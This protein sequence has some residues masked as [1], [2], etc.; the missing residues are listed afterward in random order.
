MTDVFELSYAGTPKGLMQYIGEQI[1]EDCWGEGVVYFMESDGEGHYTDTGVKTCQC[2]M[3][4]WNDR[5]E[6][7]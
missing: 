5:T 6:D 7:Q 3:I 4:D 2:Q 1:C